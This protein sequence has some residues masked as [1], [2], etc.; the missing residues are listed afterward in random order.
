[1]LYNI[2]RKSK[3]NFLVHFS[4]KKKKIISLNILS[5]EVVAAEIRLKS[6]VR[7]SD[8]G[9]EVFGKIYQSPIL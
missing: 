6:C 5:S 1:M 4:M 2:F 3:T 9:A 7:L 8:R